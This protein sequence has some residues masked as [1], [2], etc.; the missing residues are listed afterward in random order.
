MDRALRGKARFR[1][2]ERVLVY[3]DRRMPRFKIKGV[4]ERSAAA[5]LWKRTLSRIPTSYG[6]LTYIASLRDSNSGVYRHHGLMATFGREDSTRALRESHERCFL[7]WLN[8]DLESKTS[9]LRE[10]IGGLE[11]PP[12]VVLKHLAT[13]A[14]YEYQLPDSALPMERELFHRDFDMAA[15]LLSHGSGGEPG[16]RDSSPPA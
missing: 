11:D 9:D 8:L 2:L 10:F 12:A 6:R 3:N 1:P 15:A 13:T 4:L 14:G 7:E 16:G 5:D